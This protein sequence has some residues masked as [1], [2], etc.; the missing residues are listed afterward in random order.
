MSV[1]E[2]KVAGFVSICFVR[3]STNRGKVFIEV[4]S[5]FKTDTRV[6]SNL[7]DMTGSIH[8]HI[9]TALQRS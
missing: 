5:D 8:I 2:E 6:L 4:A 1:G 9:L 7:F 3:E